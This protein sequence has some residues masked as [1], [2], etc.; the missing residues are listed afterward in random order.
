[1]KTPD[2]NTIEEW[3][4]TDLDRGLSS[5]E[6]TLLAQHLDQCG[7]CRE[8]R[9]ELTRLLSTFRSDVPE[10]PGQVFWQRYH[11]SLEARVQ[12]RS[13]QRNRF[14]NVRWNYA[15]VAFAAMLLLTAA[16]VTHFQD[17]QVKPHA[18]VAMSP[19]LMQEFQQLYGP[20]PDEGFDSDGESMERLMLMV[21]VNSPRYADAYLSWFEVEDES[22]LPFL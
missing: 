6:K 9:D 17:S 12:E 11:S 22:S 18:M 5:E 20:V 8:T 13:F 7:P 1:M 19:E 21:E 2:C 10:D 3:I 15:A 16:L 14:W 4:I